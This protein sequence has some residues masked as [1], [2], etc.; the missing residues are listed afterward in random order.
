LDRPLDPA[1]RETLHAQ[2][3]SRLRAAIADGALSP[4]DRLPSTRALAA[5][6][7]VARG[8]VESAYA[9]LAGEGAVEP[10]RGSGGTVVAGTRAVRRPK[11]RQPGLALETAPPAPSEAPLPFRLGLPALDAFP[12]KAWAA[13][14][15]RAARALGP[16]DMAYP[17]PS[18]S[19]ELRAA[20]AGYLAAARGVRCPAE[21]VIVTAGFQGALSLVRAA[22]LRPGDAVWVEDPGYPP[23]IRA[24]EASGARAVPMRVDADGL[25]VAAAR[26]AAPRARLAVVTPANQSP[27]G[28]ALSLPRRLELLAWAEESGAWVL[29]D[30]YDAEFRYVGKPLPALKSLD[31][32]D[33]VFYAGS[34]SKVLH[35]GLRLGYLVPPAAMVEACRRA[36]ALGSAGTPVLE[37]KAVAAFVRS[38][39]FARHIRR[40]R[41]L[42]ARRRAALAAALDVAFGAR[43]RIEPTAGGMHLLIRLAPGVDD[44][45]LARL[46]AGRGLAATALTGLARGHHPGPGLLLGFANIAED[47]APAMARRLAE[48]LATGLGA[49]GA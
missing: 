38:G 28:A 33:R 45:G 16:A 29:E 19:P 35:P 40:M 42:Y 41:A 43:V 30:D 44:A 1:G 17:D 46:A 10:R 14:V 18:G 32:A 15:A 47:Q 36:A 31:R 6:L 13:A 49:M 48:A 12:R 8:T 20:V 3:A 27:L 5:Q 7:G 11:L 25:A 22:L 4:G 26:R 34:F 9:V 24:V 2:L 37:Q 39:A 21:R 23:A